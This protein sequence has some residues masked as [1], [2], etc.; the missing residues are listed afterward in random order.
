M[1]TRLSEAVRATYDRQPGI[2]LP[3]VYLIVLLWI[4][5]LHG[6]FN[7][8]GGVMQYFSGREILA[9]QGYGGWPAGFWPPLYSFLLGLGSSFL[10]G[11]QVGKLISTFSGAGLLYVAYDLAVELSQDR[12]VGLW[13]QVF[14]LLTPLYIHQSLM[15][16]NHMLDALLFVWGLLL[17]LKSLRRPS[18]ARLALTGVVCGLAGLT[19][20]TSYV[21]LALP[22]FFFFLPKPRRAGRLAL[23]FWGA[24]GA[25]NLP[26]WI[27][28]TLRN[29]F[30]LWTRE[31]LNA[32]VGLFQYEW[33]QSNLAV[34]W[35]CNEGFGAGGLWSLVQTHPLQYF[36]SVVGRFLHSIPMLVKNA[37]TLGPFLVPALFEGFVSLET[38]QWSVV[39]GL[40]FL[41]VSFASLGAVPD[42]GVLCWMVVTII[43]S[44]MLVIRILSGLQ[45]TYALAARSRLRGLSMALLAVIALATT[46]FKVRVYA[47]AREFGGPLADVQQVARV[48]R[49]HDPDIGSKVIM[50]IDPARA[51][52][53]GAGYLETP[54]AYDGSVAGLVAYEGL[55]GNVRAYAPKSPSAM[56]LSTL[57]A[58]Y[59]VYT[60]T[61]PDAH[62][63]DLQELPQFSFL[64]DPQSPQIPPNFRPVYQAPDVVVYEI[65]WAFP[66]ESRGA[67]GRPRGRGAA[68]TR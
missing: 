14:L 49:E 45:A 24:F 51:Y 5:P 66:V 18:P 9:G 2:R 63:W 25:V 60:R 37:G 23:V 12:S 30:P 22:A 52:Y 1:G 17:F 28:N 56:P 32:C 38:R 27:D 10:P 40:L 67:G 34:L 31:H 29:G 48:L 8:W 68:G 4:S 36:A 13:T 53:A 43:L 46:D 21:L 15:A 6:V 20:Y 50:A 42:Y 54:P 62:S 35:R 16:H 64:L 61:P 7:E 3:I 44:L 26:W 33:R 59:L 11:F 41:Y 57:R 65:E 55:D 39:Y 47:N 58:D 19:R